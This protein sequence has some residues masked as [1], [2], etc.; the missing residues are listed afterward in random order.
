MLQDAMTSIENHER[1]VRRVVES[2]VV[3]G[4]R[5]PEGWVVSSSTADD[6]EDT[7][8]MPFWSDRAYAKRAAQE[9]WAQYE[10]TPIPLH[11]FMKSWLEG[12]HADGT[13]VG[14]NW[15][16]HNCGLEVAPLQLAK[17]LQ[18]EIEGPS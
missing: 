8:V 4:L 14:T 11:E 12:M 18:A 1:F 6:D 17:D 16:A 2:G 10:P 5:S 15:D 3:W 9:D 13:L 7:N